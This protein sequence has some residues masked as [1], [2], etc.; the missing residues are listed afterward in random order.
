MGPGWAGLNTD[1]EKRRRKSHRIFNGDDREQEDNSGRSGLP[2]RWTEPNSSPQGE[3]AIR[4]KEASE[5]PIKALTVARNS[6]QEK[7]CT[8]SVLHM[9]VPPRYGTPG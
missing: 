4:G 5:E 6:E 7:T 3:T 8:N 9:P 2:R 1:Q